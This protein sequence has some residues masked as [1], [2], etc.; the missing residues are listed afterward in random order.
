MLR[1][2]NPEQIRHTRIGSDRTTSVKSIQLPPVSEMDA[3]K[4]LRE[5]LLSNPEIYF[6]RLVVL[7][8]GDSEDIV[9]PKIFE[10]AGLP[11]DE[12]GI[13][14]AQLGG[15]HVNYL[16]KLLSDLEIPYA[17]LLDL[18]LGRHQGG[19]GRLRYAAQQLIQIGVDAGEPDQFPKWNGANPLDGEKYSN[20]WLAFL[21]SH[22]V[23]FS[24]PLDLDFSMIRAF[25]ASYGVETEP[26]SALDDTT[27]KSVL[28][29]SHADISW[30]SDDERKYFDDY[31]SLF[32]VGSKPASHIQA[33]SNLKLEDIAVA[34]PQPYGELVNYVKTKLAVGYE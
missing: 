21:K 15:R 11:M 18:D 13:I 7:G 3:H 12:N 22:G 16:W 29:K 20:D 25:P 2:I 4:F 10:A 14:L 34:L 19:W 17:T 33:L 28:G 6:A 24:F 26:M 23:F 8:E 31:H 32:K 1:R 30:Y 5:G 27:C 9:L